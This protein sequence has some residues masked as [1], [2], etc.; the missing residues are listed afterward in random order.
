VYNN[1]TLG[2]HA[3]G[4]FCIGEKKMDEKKLFK[5]ICRKSDLTEKDE[6]LIGYF[7]AEGEYYFKGVNFFWWKGKWISGDTSYFSREDF[8]K[9]VVKFWEI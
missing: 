7:G 2:A 4:L 1:Q 6:I 8:E 9:A 5:A 3:P